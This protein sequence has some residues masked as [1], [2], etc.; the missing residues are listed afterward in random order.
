MGKDP[1]SSLKSGFPEAETHYLPVIGLYPDQDNLV[2]LNVAGQTYEFTIRPNEIPKD[3]LET[4]KVVQSTAAELA[5]GLYFFSP[6]GREGYLS[7]YDVNGDL[8]WILTDQLSWGIQQLKNGHML[9][10]T[11]RLVNPPY[12]MLVC[13]RSTCWERFTTNTHYQG[14][15]ITTGSNCPRAISWWHQMISII[16]RGQSKIL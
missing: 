14:D 15:I 4:A 8:R 5:P 2:V 7:A 9:V 11:E 1:S 6:A 12:Y 10:S 16:P 13:M 3:A